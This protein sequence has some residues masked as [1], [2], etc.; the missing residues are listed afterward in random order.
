MIYQTIVALSIASIASAKLFVENAESQK[1]MWEEF[2]RSNNRNYAT[3]DEETQRFGFFIENLKSVD[4]R[5]AAEASAGGS[6][7][8]G[9]TKFSDMSQM[10]F[11]K[12]MLSADVGMKTRGAIVADVP[13]YTGPEALVD[14]SGVL[15]TP[16]KDQGYCG[17]CWAFSATEQI[18]S[19]V[20]RTQKITYVLSPQQIT[21]C[22]TAAYG[23]S[24]GWT[25]VAYQ[26]VTKAG[27]SN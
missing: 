20:M 19:D 3:M 23:C 26:Y 24:G 14:W 1:Y 6:A 16:V 13:A 11:E 25:E 9:I 18:E 17:S 2:K 15:S 12:K 10:E 5:N 8:H 27:V 4:E 22:A 7:V 21:S